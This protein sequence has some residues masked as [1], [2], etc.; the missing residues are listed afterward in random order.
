LKIPKASRF[1]VVGF[2]SAWTDSSKAPGAICAAHIDAAG[3]R[4]FSNP[5]LATFED[6]TAFIKAQYARSELCLVAIDQPTIVNNVSG[7][8]PAERVVASAISYVGGGVQ[9]ANRSKANMFG[10]DAP[11]WRFKKAL[12]ASDSIEA[13]VPG[14]AGLFMAEV[15]PAFALLT[16]NTALWGRKLAPKYN[17]VNRKK[18]KLADWKS[19]TSTVAKIAREQDLSEAAAWADRQNGNPTPQKADQDKIDAVICALIG[20]RWLFDRRDNNVMIGDLTSGYI[21]S[22]CSPPI[23]ERLSIKAAELGVSFK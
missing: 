6:A 19:V 21:I 20:M 18:L 23:R 10:D 12:N 15:F 5:V 14:H 16:F 4:S 1:C 3:L 8:R 2:D 13:C 17:P 22:P 9:P 7:S 11:I